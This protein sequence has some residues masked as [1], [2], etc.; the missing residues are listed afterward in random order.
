MKPASFTYNT[1]NIF[2]SV[3]MI[4][5]LVWL[6]VSLPLVTKYQQAVVTEKMSQNKASNSEK[7]DS[8]NPFANTTEE[9]NPNSSNTLAEEFLH[10]SCF[11]QEHLPLPVKYNKCT[12]PAVY[13]AF[14][15]ELLSPPP[16][17]C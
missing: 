3:L 15:G 9:K 12:H 4:M 6:T 1:R 8:G 11:H 5:T 14:H 2:S 16:E 17:A 13:V 10:E 7:K